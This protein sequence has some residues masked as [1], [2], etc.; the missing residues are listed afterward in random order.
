M[1]R[2]FYFLYDSIT[3]KFYTGQNN[4]LT[5]FDRAAVYHSHDAAKTKV[6]AVINSWKFS[7]KHRDSY[8]A[9]VKPTNAGDVAWL[10][11]LDDGIATH[12]NAK[13]W[14]VK[15]VEKTLNHP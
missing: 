6:K 12:C 8:A 1:K 4:W 11:D 2:S 9:R 3:G 5:D 13:D 10:K 14:G 7:Q 15:I